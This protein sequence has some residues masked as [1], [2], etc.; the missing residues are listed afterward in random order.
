[1]QYIADCLTKIKTKSFLQRI[2][3]ALK[4]KNI[5]IKYA[6]QQGWSIYKIYSDDDFSGLDNQRPAW[7]EM[8]KDAKERKF[9]IILC[10]SQS[11]FTRDMEVVEKYL[12]NKFIEWGIRFI[13]LT[14]NSDTL[15]KG[16]KKQRQINGLV[17][18][19]Y[20]ED[21]SENIKSVFDMKRKE[22]KFIGSFACYGYKKD[23]KNKN[24]LLIDEEAAQVIRMIFK[25]YLEGYG[26]QRIAYM[27]N[28]KVFLAPK[29]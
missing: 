15:N 18:E 26:T 14:D 5:L 16:N 17:N 28:Q 3:K 20:C 10:K 21:V 19:W 13:G 8:I 24:K 11:R 12:H 27:L 1:M 4:I 7:N 22:G 23:P 29:I 9:N 6:A 2:L 25:W